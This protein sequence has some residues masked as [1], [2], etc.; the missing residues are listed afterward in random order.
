MLETGG[1]AVGA[2]DGDG[3]GGRAEGFK[4]FV[5]LL[6]VIEGGRH[7]VEAEEGVGDE[8]WG[9]P[10]FGFGAVVA[11]DVAVDWNWG[12]SE[13]EGQRWGT[14]TVPSRTLKPMSS[15]LMVLTHGGGNPILKV[16]GE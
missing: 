14:V 15:Q 9:R 4:T 2:E 7:A 12:V 16:E 13:V 5:G 11:L 6:A 8:F 10:L 3:V 1:V